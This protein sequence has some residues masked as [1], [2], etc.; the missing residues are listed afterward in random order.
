MIVLVI[1]IVDIIVI[2]AVAAAES[3]ADGAAAEYHLRS[4]A[5]GAADIAAA[6]DACCMRAAL[7]EDEAVVGHTVH[8]AAAIDGTRNGTCA[9][10]AH[11]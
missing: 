10:L 3:A 2:V 1:D 11:V 6:I 8:L 9:G 4:V 5:D 7:N